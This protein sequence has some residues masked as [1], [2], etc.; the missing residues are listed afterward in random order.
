LSACSVHGALPPPV[1]D[2]VLTGDQI[3]FIEG[4]GQLP[5]GTS[6]K[7]EDARAAGNACAAKVWKSRFDAKAKANQ[8]A[9]I[10]ESTR[11]NRA[12]AIASDYQDADT[13]VC[14]PQQKKL[15]ALFEAALSA[16]KQRRVSLYQ[17]IG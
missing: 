7:I 10:T 11:E 6:Q 12:Q 8:V 16:Y 4:V 9:N 1:Q 13:K 14:A 15:S 2:Y 3:K 17:S 5:K